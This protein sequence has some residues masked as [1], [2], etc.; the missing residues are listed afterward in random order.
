MKLNASEQK[1]TQAPKDYPLN[2][3]IDKHHLYFLPDKEKQTDLKEFKVRYIFQD[4]LLKINPHEI[5]QILRLKIVFRKQYE[6]DNPVLN[7]AFGKFTDNDMLRILHACDFDISH[8]CEVILDSYSELKKI[9]DVDEIIENKEWCFWYYPYKFRDQQTDYFMNVI[10]NG[11]LYIFGR[12]KCLRPIL[13]FELKKIERQ[14]IGPESMI[15]AYVCIRNYLWG[16]QLI[17]GQ[18]END[19]II[20]NHG[21]IKMTVMNQHFLNCVKVLERDCYRPRLSM[22]Y[23]IYHVG[24]VKSLQKIVKLK[25][26]KNCNRHLTKVRSTKDKFHEEMYEH[27]SKW[28]LEKKFGGYIEDVTE[29]WWPPKTPNRHYW[30]DS[31]K[32]RDN[33]ITPEAYY[34]KY[35]QGQFDRLAS[36]ICWNIIGF[37]EKIEERGYPLGLNER[38]L[39]LNAIGLENFENSVDPESG[40]VEENVDDLTVDEGFYKGVGMYKILSDVHK[41][42]RSVRMPDDL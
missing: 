6:F 32:E 20:I 10:D 38:K 33:L 3:L 25:V 7:K 28:Q 15:N 19:V 14:L 36:R 34:R 17:P 12:D 16:R 5:K 26:L 27:I 21:G 29:N 39:F 37:Y 40:Q 1:Q 9:C 24:F 23:R 22:A 8:A 41:K 13:V 31:E 11:G 42:V 18:I 30:L 4:P 35:K 2:D